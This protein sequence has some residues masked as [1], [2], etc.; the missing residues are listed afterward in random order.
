MCRNPSNLSAIVIVY[1]LQT[2]VCRRNMLCALI[3]IYIYVCVR[4]R[5]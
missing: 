2:H 3:Y 5:V 1:I 4:V